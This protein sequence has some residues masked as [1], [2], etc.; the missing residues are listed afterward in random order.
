[1]QGSPLEQSPHLRDKSILYLMLAGPYEGV[2]QGSDHYIPLDQLGVTRGEWKQGFPGV[3]RVHPRALRG[4]GPAR[5][6]GPDPAGEVNCRRAQAWLGLDVMG[7]T[8]AEFNPRPLLVS[9]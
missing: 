4:P 8:R 2:P 7:R 1:M 5:K 6:P 3:R 9:T